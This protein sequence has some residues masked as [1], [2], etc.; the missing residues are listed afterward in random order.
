MVRTIYT[1][2]SDARLV[3]RSMSDSGLVG[4]LKSPLRN[5]GDG[6]RGVGEAG[7]RGSGGAGG[8][9]GR[10]DGWSHLQVVKRGVGEWGSGRVEG[11]F[12]KFWSRLKITV[13]LIYIASHFPLILVL[14]PV[15]FSIT[16]YMK[17][18]F[19]NSLLLFSGFIL[20]Q[21]QV[22]VKKRITFHGKYTFQQNLQGISI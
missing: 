2:S 13:C 4:T 17:K 14:T 12:A 21:C 8:W 7:K 6:K 5:W 9:K 20:Q 10:G 3:T 19:F 16:M 18:L 1:K 22:N 15:G 11:Y